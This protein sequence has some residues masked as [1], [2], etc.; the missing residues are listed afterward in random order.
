MQNLLIPTGNTKHLMCMENPECGSDIGTKGVDNLN[1]QSWRIV[2]ADE[3]IAQG[4]PLP[5]GLR[6]P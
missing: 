3:R 1:E 5:G 4:T 6:R 2:G